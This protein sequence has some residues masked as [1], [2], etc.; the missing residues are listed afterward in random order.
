MICHAGGRLGIYISS[1]LA[2]WIDCFTN[3]EKE[4]EIMTVCTV[5]CT[6]VGQYIQGK[7]QANCS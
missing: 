6:T 5:Y 4:M 7:L 2:L 3:G 1:D